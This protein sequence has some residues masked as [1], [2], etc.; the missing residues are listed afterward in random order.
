MMDQYLSHQNYTNFNDQSVF[1]LTPTYKTP[2]FGSWFFNN[3]EEDTASDDDMGFTQGLDPV[4]F[5]KLSRKGQTGGSKRNQHRRRRRKRK[6]I[7]AQQSSY[8]S[9]R[10][11]IL[12]INQV[13]R[14]EF[15]LPGR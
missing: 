14:A 6:R 5:I 7:V 15:L 4:D 8:G 1:N 10:K 11:E 2:R 3:Q 12:E 9:K 13:P